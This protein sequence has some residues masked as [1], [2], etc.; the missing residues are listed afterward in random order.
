MF[1]RESHHHACYHWPIRCRH[2]IPSFSRRR[3]QNHSIIFHNFISTHIHTY[4]AYKHIACGIVT[5]QHY[6]LYIQSF[7]FFL[8]FF[9]FTLHAVVH[10]YLHTYVRRQA[11]IQYGRY[12]YRCSNEQANTR[13]IDEKNQKLKQCFSLC[14]VFVFVMNLIVY[15]R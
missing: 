4:T 8:S 3:R 6:S 5:V 7:S 1:I 10:S 2:K 15:F 13:K 12:C 14:I 11:T 9:I